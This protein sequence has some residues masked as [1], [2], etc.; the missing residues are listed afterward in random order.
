MKVANTHGWIATDSGTRIVN[1]GD[2]EGCVIG[3]SIEADIEI[4]AHR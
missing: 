1:V 4:A 3:D 2:P